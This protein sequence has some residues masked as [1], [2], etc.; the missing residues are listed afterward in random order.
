MAQQTC[1]G[2]E[3]GVSSR[4]PPRTSGA[5]SVTEEAAFLKIVRLVR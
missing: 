4:F 3:H 1:Y 2:G 5:G